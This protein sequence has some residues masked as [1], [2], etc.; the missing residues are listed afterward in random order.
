MKDNQ[1]YKLGILVLLFLGFQKLV[2]QPQFVVGDKITF[3]MTPDATAGTIPLDS[4]HNKLV[5]LKRSRYEKT[6]LFS[7]FNPHPT[8]V[9]DIEGYT[10]LIV[11]ANVN[12]VLAELRFVKQ[13]NNV[14]IDEKFKNPTKNTDI[15]SVTY[16]ELNRKATM[17]TY[18][19]YKFELSINAQTGK[20]EV[21]DVRAS[22]NNGQLLPAIE[23][24]V[25][26]MAK[27][28]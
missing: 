3:S 6:N 20:I 5:A 21:V 16:S 17:E 1:S 12:K 25:Y 26:K 2:A 14:W 10:I 11:V 13:K 4:I 19:G 23:S 28:F 9:S 27:L 7:W 24:H 8:T 22:A 15:K 18:G